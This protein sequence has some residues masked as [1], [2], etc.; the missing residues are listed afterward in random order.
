MAVRSVWRDWCRRIAQSKML[1]RKRRAAPRP[2]RA[3]VLEARCLLSVIT[4]TSLADNLAVDGK[5]TLREAIQAANTN[6]SVDGSAAGQSSSQDKIV[7]QNGL[8]GTIKLNPALG[9]LLITD[10]VQIVGLGAKNTVIDAQ[11][12]SRVFEVS[13]GAGNVTLSSLTVTGGQ[14]TA[15]LADGGGIL[16]LSP[17]LLTLSNA[18]VTN[19]SVTGAGGR[20]AGIFTDSGALTVLGSTISGNSNAYG[21]GDGGGIFSQY[22]AVTLTNSTLANNSVAGYNAGGAGIYASGAGA[23]VTLTNSTISG[24]VDT[25]PNGTGGAIT[26]VRSSLAIVNSIVSGNTISVGGTPDITFHYRGAATF[27]ASHSLIGV[28]YGTPVHPT[29]V[30]S[31]D[32]NGN[33]VGTFA[34]PLDARLGPLA[35]NGGQTQTMALLLGSPA[36]N[37]GANALAVAPDGTALK[38]DQRGMGFQRIIDTTVEMGSFEFHLQNVPL[39]VTTATDVFHDNGIID[40]LQLSLRDAVALANAHTGPDKITFA[41]FLAG[42]PIDLSLGEP[43]ITDSVQIVGLGA[44]NTIIDAQQNS[45]VFEMTAIAGNVTLSAL[46]VTNGETTATL[47]HGGGILFLSPGVLTLTNVAVTNNSV[48][49]PGSLGG[50]IYTNSGAVTALNSTISGN[51]NGY[52]SRDG[53]GIF[54]QNGAVTLTN[55][56]LAN[57]SVHGYN[58]GGAA[59][60]AFN[61]G[62]V[63]TLTNCT[64]SGNVDT[65]PTGGG[66][67]ITTIRPALTILNSIISGNTV[68]AGGSQDIDFI[69]YTG[70]ATF[71][72]S[73][74]LIGIYSGTPLLP[75]PV[76]TPD[77]NGNLLG[78]FVH[79]LDARLGPLADNGGPTQTMALLL[80]STAI[81]AGANTLAVGP[82]GKAL[83]YDQRG[84]GFPRIND[85]IVDMGSFEFH[86]PTFP[87]VVTTASDVLDDVPDPAHLS[88]RDAVALANTNPGPDTIT[89]APSLAGVPIDLSLGELFITDSV[90]I[91]GLGAK[92]TVIDAQHNSRV[93]EV[94]ATAGDVTFNMLTVTGGMTTADGETGAG[95][96]FL[97]TGKLLI[98]NS[99]VTGSRTT[100]FG[101]PG[102]GIY[103]QYGAVTILNSTISGNSV[104]AD[105]VDGGGIYTLNGNVVVT[106]STL[107][108]NSTGGV[109]GDG[110]AIYAMNGN[111]TLTN[112][113]VSQNTTA[114]IQSDAGGI[115]TIRGSLT[116]RNSIVSGNT[117][118]FGDAN[119]THDIAFVN[120]SYFATFTASH[121][122]IGI[123]TG[124]PLAPAPVG[125]PDANGN[126]VGTYASPLDAK[127][128]PLA[129]NGGQ[130]QTMALLTGSPAINAGD[131]TL[132]VAPDG[133][134]LKTDQRG[135]GFTRVVGGTVDMGAFE[136]QSAGGN[137]TLMALGGLSVNDPRRRPHHQG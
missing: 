90:Q 131:N 82:D 80:G 117:V 73:H 132:A 86:F 36:I 114:F 12:N 119:S 22:G 6:A 19:N 70:G 95:I 137:T 136:V 42:V 74:N 8:V 11:H 23:T 15:A 96:R 40:P 3:E 84:P 28:Y 56:T 26:T 110:G 66:A 123:N 83:K 112:S 29:P 49:G 9:E 21:A 47:A 45:R 116:L 38:F 106:N 127:L 133:S 55:S 33:L 109:Y 35:D 98:Q 102:G 43:L 63:V 107:S 128:G 103:T 97:S 20:G 37:A 72:A 25:G 34:H 54:S 59:V 118:G 39:V 31:P 16:F 4:V 52:Y 115:K 81:N 113:T 105:H 108:R 75:P 61:P 88:L 27:T 77:A 41:P 124:T 5:V 14:T 99:A 76:G 2:W 17:G 126:L 121:S 130:T 125:S 13:P 32:G 24:N 51:S 129:D 79:P 1:P 122:L 44:K 65:G 62:A 94:G 78:S 68:S 67:A 46:T 60:Y 101:A 7:F 64:V 48:V 104:G 120:Y 134:T 100:G 71:T 30:G 93:F 92:N 50:G 135:T 89:F 10:S 87:L 111:V 91:T 69:N 18:A 58:S 85:T 57:N 53:G